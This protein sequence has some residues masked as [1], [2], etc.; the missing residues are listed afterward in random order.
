MAIPHPEKLKDGK[1]GVN[2][3]HSGV[4]GE[5]AYFYTPGTSDMFG[6]GVADGI[7][8]WREFGIDSGVFSKTLMDT[9]MHL[10]EAGHSD[11]LRI[12]QICMRKVQSEGVYGSST[13]CI[14]VLDR[15][16]ARMHSSLVQE[17][18]HGHN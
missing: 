2:L 15:A 6:L 18:D 11:V 8:M 1:R 10:V 3:R 5:D 16:S 17:R 13:F 4:A 7:Y 12:A 14:A 9:A